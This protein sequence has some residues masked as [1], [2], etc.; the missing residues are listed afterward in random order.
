MPRAGDPNGVVVETLI[1][2]RRDGGFTMTDQYRGFSIVIGEARLVKGWW[3]VSFTLHE[4]HPVENIVWRGR[5][6]SCPGRA[7]ILNGQFTT[8]EAAEQKAME[9]A[10]KEISELLTIRKMVPQLR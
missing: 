10:R 8:K 7:F 1:F 4:D 6:L 9:E 5:D 3:T 2:S